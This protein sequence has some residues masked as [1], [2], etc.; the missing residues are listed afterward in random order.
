MYSLGNDNHL[1]NR[2][3]EVPVSTKNAGVA[4]GASELDADEDETMAMEDV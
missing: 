3:L 2:L 1:K 4:Q